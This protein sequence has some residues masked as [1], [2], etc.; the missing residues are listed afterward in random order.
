VIVEVEHSD[1]S[2]D[3]AYYFAAN[4]NRASLVLE[5]FRKTLDANI[6]LYDGLLSSMQ[7]HERLQHST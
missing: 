5:G 6:Y 2:I 3:L 7:K 4:H 1:E